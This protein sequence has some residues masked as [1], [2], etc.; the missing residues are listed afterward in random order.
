MDAA[1]T[2]FL[3]GAAPPD[4]DLDDPDERS[5]LLRR[6]HGD[7]SALQSAVRD[8]VATQIL[9]DQPPQTWQAAQRLLDQGLDGHD[10][11]G[12]LVL[13]FTPYVLDALSGEHAFDTDRYAESLSRLPLPGVHAVREALLTAAS[14]RGRASTEELIADAAGALGVVADDSGVQ[15][16]LERLLDD[17]LDE[18]SRVQM[19][20]GDLIVDVRGLLEGAVLTTVLDAPTKDLL[21]DAWV[22]L[23]A[24]D[25]LDAEAT[26][27]PVS[28]EQPGAVAVRLVD[29]T[30][31]VTA[32]ATE[33]AVDPAL[34]SLLRRCYDR[35]VE[36]PWLPVVV[37][38][39]VLAA[40]AEQPDCFATAQAPLTRLVVAAGLEL[41][42][43]EV[44]HEASVWRSA[45]DF[46]AV[47]RLRA[48][49]DEEDFDAV[50]HVSGLVGVDLDRAGARAALDLLADPVVLETAV[51]LL[52]G[53]TDDLERLATTAELATRLASAA[54]RPVQHAVAGWLLAVVAERE[55]RP[56]D[57][58]RLLRDA[59]HAD[60][61]WTPAVDRLAWCLSD[62]GDATR[63][64][65][66]WEGLG[67][68][69]EDSDDIRELHSLPAAPAAELGRNDRC[70]CGSGRKFKQCHLGRPEPL[71][72]P[73]RVGWLCRKATAYLER[74]GGACQDDVV[75]AVMARAVDGDK[76]SVL[77]ALQDPLVLDTVLHEGGWFDRFL[78]DRGELLP[79]DELLLGQ[80]WTLV[81]RTVYEVEQTRPG[82]GVTVRDLATGERFEVRERTFSR[83][84]K[85][86]M[87]ICARAVPDGLTHQFIGGL[88]V[89]EPGR[90]ELLLDLL[91]TGDGEALL[92][93]VAA[94]HRPPV[95]IGPGGEKIELGAAPVGPSP[96]PVV[97]DPEIARQVMEHLEL[98]WCTEPVPALAGL[99]PEQAA[100]D[101]TRRDDVRRLIDSFPEPDPAH[102]QLGLRP[103]SLRERLGLG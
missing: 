68:T 42:G 14:R 50:L 99:T 12:E 66:L 25:Q 30:P 92:A 6:H 96:L 49:L 62:R 82:E 18:A 46:Q 2:T 95:L 79:A 102:G 21:H 87:R 71:P 83:T 36:E 16:L 93:Y 40:L 98:R 10:V 53:R 59:V 88:F 15:A 29:G 7:D 19:L 56:Q 32:L 28:Y 1:R 74:R 52:L 67:R 39:L 94:R 27:P 63:A 26:A 55:G 76:D 64:L 103:S 44:A 77:A 70:W 47:A 22:D 81:D 48:Q 100:A 41:R 97:P 51:D 38:E 23:A 73:D 69:A 20:A 5:A 101:P 90:E 3:F 86:G 58:E 65:A 34:V 9:Q 72:L 80:A 24:F 91:S 35:A 84:A 43:G 8:A 11:M 17:L 57:A 31:D 4:C 85:V 61:G 75:D 33:P 13:T 54:S 89:A 60:P 45:E 37:E 78:A